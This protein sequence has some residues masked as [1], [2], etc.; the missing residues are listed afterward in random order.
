MV[1]IV[2]HHSNV[3]NDPAYAYQVEQI[4]LTLKVVSLGN[5]LETLTN[6]FLTVEQAKELSE[7]LMRHVLACRKL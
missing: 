3:S 6:Y 7:E 5:N 4:K 2:V 1:E